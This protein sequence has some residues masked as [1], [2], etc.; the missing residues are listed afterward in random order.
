MF[1]MPTGIFL[2]TAAAASAVLIVIVLIQLWLEKLI[3]FYNLI[4]EELREER[5]RS[6]IV[7]LLAAEIIV[8]AVGPTLFYYWIYAVLPFFSYRAGVAVGIFLY[9]FGV[10]P[11]AIGLVL[12]M[13][14]PGGV[15]VFTFFFTILKLVACWGMV[16]YVMNI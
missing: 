3:G 12:R 1:G 15:M 2:E 13:K 5:S 16:T 4:P 14:L 11:F 10:L 7:I 9:L 8:F 6:W